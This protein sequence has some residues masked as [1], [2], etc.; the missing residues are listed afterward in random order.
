LDRSP[1]RHRAH[2]FIE[3]DDDLVIGGSFND[4][5]AAQTRNAENMTLT[6]S[7]EVAAEYVA[8]WNRR[9]GVSERFVP[10]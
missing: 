8:Y 1:H 5:A 3:I 4:A 9:R 10:R 6:R 7:A 2:Q